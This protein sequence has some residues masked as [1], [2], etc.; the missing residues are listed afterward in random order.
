MKELKFLQRKIGKK[1]GE[2]SFNYI[3]FFSILDENDI[4]SLLEDI[5]VV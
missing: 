4:L 1:I 2:I 3:E 5:I